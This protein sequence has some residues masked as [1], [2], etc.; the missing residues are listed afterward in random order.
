M[1]AALR[2][3]AGVAGFA[4]KTGLLRHLDAGRGRGCTR[5]R[6]AGAAAV[7]AAGVAAAAR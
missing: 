5:P 2:R 6:R 3:R 1:T 4:Q 7:A